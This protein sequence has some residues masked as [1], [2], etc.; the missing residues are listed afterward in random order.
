MSRPMVS[1]QGGGQV[2]R[3]LDGAMPPQQ[4]RPLG[5]ASRSSIVKTA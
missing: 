4:Q 1:V 3:V 5:P 2:R